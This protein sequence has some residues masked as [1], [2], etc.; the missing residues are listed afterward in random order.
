M[1]L[2]WHHRV[3]AMTTTALTA[4]L[5]LAV[6]SPTTPALAT[7]AV[8]PGAGLES[9]DHRASSS[10]SDLPDIAL[11]P[12]GEAIITDRSDSP[13]APGVTYTSFDRLDPR[14]WVRGDV[15]SIDMARKGVTFDYLNSGTVASTG[16]LTSQAERRGAIAAVNGDGFDINDTGA[17][18][19][20]GVQRRDGGESVMLNGSAAGTS[21]TRGESIVVGK[22]G[23]ASLA[24]VVLDGRATDGTDSVTLTNLNSPTVARNGI[25]LYT[26]AWGN[27]A[28]NRTLDGAPNVYEVVIRDGVV[29]EADA[30][31][32]HP[33][34]S[35]NEQVLV[36]RDTGATRLAEAFTVGESVDVTYAPKGADDLSMALN[37][38][39]PV[40][41]DGQI[42]T[43]N[44]TDLHP[45]TIVGLN[46]DGSRM[47]LVTVDGRQ[48]NSRGLTEV[49][50]AKLLLDMGATDVVNLDGGGSSQM[51]ARLAG[52]LAPTIK[53]SP[54]DGS[55]RHTANSLGLFATPGSGRLA[56][57][58]IRAANSAWK[59]SDADSSTDL[60]VME[61]LSRVV[62][63]QG[64]D[65][66]Y[67]PIL[68][69][70]ASLNAGPQGNVTVTDENGAGIVTGKRRGST[71]LVARDAAVSSS[72]KV[73]VLGAPER[74]STSTRQVSLA[75]NEVTGQFQVFGHDREGMTTW[76]EPRDVTL[77]YD[78]SQIE[79]TA[80]DD[81]FVVT[82]LVESTSTVIKVNAGGQHT[83]VAVTVGL[84]TKVLST[85]D[86]ISQ[87]S[88]TKF[89]AVVGSRISAAE[90]RTPGGQGVAL[91]YSLTGTTAT[92]AAYVAASPRLT[93]TGDAP[94]ST[95]PPAAPPRPST[96]CATSTGPGGS[97]SRQPSRPAWSHRSPSSA[98]T[99][100]RPRPPAS[101]AAEWSSTT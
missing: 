7:P 92:R 70:R 44:D 21:T 71:D 84:G 48:A 99:S 66:T 17:P 74:I 72:T 62:S 49:E 59:D 29:I 10:E 27:V 50:T 81:H 101:T 86:D 36:A 77:D 83:E 94:T 26:Q 58:R 24:N 61:G 73:V 3:L 46:K 95:R 68:T 2:P 37:S 12:A 43:R 64:V 11:A 78:R 34:P 100:S 63:A 57:F 76:V 41:H 69:S 90:G 87:W 19:G 38:F 89:P 97:T 8:P 45:R 60:W 55:E 4:T 67:S 33:R 39:F 5:A 51:N 42:T 52:E 14:G 15:L 47:W 93:M 25:A 20:T 75:S 82:P 18:L 35:E 96:W 85:M 6:A 1:A 22:N 79:V 23:L 13:V 65:E 88:A 98:S 32:D 31:V 53:S 30:N 16:T 54:S 91:D 9:P 28:I 40:A 56:E 80:R